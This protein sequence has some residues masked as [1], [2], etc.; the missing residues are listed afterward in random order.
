M[1]NSNIEYPRTQ[2]FEPEHLPTLTDRPLV[3]QVFLK[4]GRGYVHT[5]GEIYPPYTPDRCDTTVQP[6]VTKPLLSR[7]L[8]GLW[9]GD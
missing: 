4:S 9:R 7:L 3:R 8:R 6:Q 1:T 5:L 2:I